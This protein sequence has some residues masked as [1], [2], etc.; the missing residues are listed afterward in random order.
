MIIGGTYIITRHNEYLLHYIHISVN[1]RFDLFSKPYTLMSLPG[2]LY[3]TWRAFLCFLSVIIFILG[4]IFIVL[5]Q[6]LIK[7][8][9]RFS[10]HYTKVLL[11]SS[12]KSFILLLI[13]IFRINS[14]NTKIRLTVPK[15]LNEKQAVIPESKD[16]NVLVKTVLDKQ[17]IMIAN[18]QIYTDWVYLWWL[19]YTSNLGG[20]VYI[21]LKKSLSYIPLLGYG[22]KNYEFIFLSRK[23]QEDQIT[24]HNQLNEIDRNGRGLGRLN[25]MIPEWTTPEGKFIWTDKSLQSGNIHEAGTKWPY[26]LILFPEGTNLSANTRKKSIKYAEKINKQPFNNVLLPHVTGLYTIIKSLTS[27]KYLYDVTIAYSGVD[28]HEY[29]QDIYTMKKVFLEGKSPQCIDIHINLVKTEDIPLKNVDEFSDWL[30]KRWEIKDQL[31][32]NYY[33]NDGVFYKDEEKSNVISGIYDCC[34]S[35]KEYLQILFVPCLTLWVVLQ[36]FIKWVFK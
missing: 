29:A 10:P 7:T 11:D 2:I 3:Q 25:G 12:K 21:L 1:Q 33:D 24:L 8:I 27:C 26:Q 36:A 18:H 31:L 14:R 15:E 34:C 19:S 30:F 6:V 16:H 23:W 13:T 9:V 22:M 35:S 5:Q 4:A 20:S 32:E 28:R 17:S